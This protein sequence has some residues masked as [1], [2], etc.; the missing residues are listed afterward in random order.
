MAEQPAVATFRDDFLARFRWVDGHADVLGLFSDGEF[1]AAAGR[2]L[3]EPFAA[4]GFTK[5]ASVEARG[6]VLGTAVALHAG[7]GFVPIRKAGSV[8][9]GPKLTRRA[10]ADWRGNEP[11][12][13]VQRAALTCGDRVL[14]VDDWAERGSQ[15]L[16]A[17][18]L[19][20]DCGAAY[21]GLSL[22]VDQLPEATRKRLHPVAA[23]VA[24]AELPPSA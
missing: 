4:S 8:H 6:F 14:V 24:H 20:E 21:V 15:A 11:E 3:A 12:L 7:V 22:L 16:T 18:S 19:I 1:L 2:A 10:E 9:P 23:V 17:R 5:V 13:A